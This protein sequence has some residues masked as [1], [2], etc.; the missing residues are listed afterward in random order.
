M[1]G[2]PIRYLNRAGLQPSLSFAIGF[3]GFTLGWD[4]AR[5]WHFFAPS[6]IRCGLLGRRRRTCACAL[7][8]VRLRRMWHG[9]SCLR[10]SSRADRNGCPTLPHSIAATSGTLALPSRGCTVSLCRGGG[11]GGS[12]QAGNRRQGTGDGRPARSGNAASTTRT[13]AMQ[14]AVGTDEDWANGKAGTLEPAVPGGNVRQ[15]CAASI[16]R[17]DRGLQSASE[18]N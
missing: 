2:V 15:S 3:L 14:E 10:A 7:V 18:V 16:R 6:L 17:G 9:H 8:R 4:G 13:R 12:V 5:R 11:R 1:E